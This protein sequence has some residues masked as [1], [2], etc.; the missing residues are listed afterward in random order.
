MKT[1]ATLI[2][3]LILGLC[4]RLP[5]AAQ[6]SAGEVL[7]RELRRPPSSPETPAEEPAAEADTAQPAE[8]HPGNDAYKAA[9]EAWRAGD[10]A[11]ARV[12]L[13]EALTQEP[14][15]VAA[16]KSLVLLD[17]EQG[18]HAEALAGAEAI[19]TR[20]PRDPAMLRSVAEAAGALGDTAKASATLDQLVELDRSPLATHLIYN[21]GVRAWNAEQLEPAQRRFEQVLARD[22]ELGET[23][24]ILAR[25]HARKQEH[26]KALELAERGLDLDPDDRDLLEIC[27]QAHQALGNFAEAQM[28]LLE[29]EE[30]E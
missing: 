17:L 15:F 23:L 1:R 4:P 8:A 16:E 14:G 28:V 6:D 2:F 20:L 27:Y 9:L 25:L 24:E 10:L 29:I 5:L 22:P 7:R 19:L 12:K 26:E 30:L 11:T 3:T 13:G 21:D 18:R